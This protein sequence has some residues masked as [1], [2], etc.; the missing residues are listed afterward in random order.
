MHLRPGALSNI[1]ELFI[2]PIAA[3][4]LA[5]AAG[6]ALADPCKA[7]PDR[8]PMPAYLYRGAAFSGRPA[9]KTAPERIA[10]VG[11]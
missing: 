8:G 3:T 2:G 5:L 7:I 4:V 1:R 11:W 9:A 10:P 6:E